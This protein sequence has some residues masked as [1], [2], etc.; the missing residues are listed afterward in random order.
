MYLDSILLFA[1]KEKELENLVQVVR[2]Y[3]DNIA[4]QIMKNGK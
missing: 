1:K 3:S 4:M 2:I